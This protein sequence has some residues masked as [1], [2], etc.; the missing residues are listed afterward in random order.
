MRR[1]SRTKTVQLIDRCALGPV[2]RGLP[3]TRSRGSRIS[4]IALVAFGAGPRPAGPRRSHLVQAA[5]ALENDLCLDAGFSTDQLIRTSR[6][7]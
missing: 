3:A 5:S 7:V 1:R 6:P 4:G 2:A